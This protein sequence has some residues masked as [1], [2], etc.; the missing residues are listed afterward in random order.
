LKAENSQ[1]VGDYLLNL[2][3]SVVAGGGMISSNNIVVDALVN[4]KYNKAMEKNITMEFMINDLSAIKISPENIVII[5]GNA[6][7]NDIEASA[8]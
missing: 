6:L 2:H 7:D 5:L 8:Q 4:E 1:V 3:N